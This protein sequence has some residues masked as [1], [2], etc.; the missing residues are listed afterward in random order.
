MSPMT[1]RAA[2]KSSSRGR[3]AGQQHHVVGRDVAVVPVLGVQHG[4]RL[5]QRVQQRHQQQASSGARACARQSS[6]SVMPSQNG[7]TM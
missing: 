6:R 4:Q 3:A 2:P 5:G 1:W 7:I